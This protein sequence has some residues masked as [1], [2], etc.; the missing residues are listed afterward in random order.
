[1]QIKR[2][3]KRVHLIYYLLV[4]EKDSEKLLGHIVDITTSGFQL[5]SRVAISA[6]TAYRLK[7][8]LPAGIQETSREIFFEATC[9][10]SKKNIYSDF[11]GSGFNYKDIASED[12]KIIKD[13][14]Q[15]FG[16]IE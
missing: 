3:Q 15:L 14:I 1:M 4:F 13:L 2:A 10:W 8:V 7:M 11:Y 12:F 6:D 5:L 16:Y 9:I